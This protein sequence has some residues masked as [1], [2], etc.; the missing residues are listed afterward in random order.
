MSSYASQSRSAGKPVVLALGHRFAD[1]S[2]EQGVLAEAA[3]L[4]DA[5]GMPEA[6]VT[7]ALRTAHGVLIGSQ[8]SLRASDLA[9]LAACRVIVR[10]GSGVDN[11]DVQAA[12]RLGI[13]VGYVP[14]YC[15]EEVATHVVALILAANRNLLT[16]TRQA[17]QGDWAKPS[18][19]GIRRL[20]GQTAGVVGFGRIGRKVAG[21]LASLG[22]RVLVSDPALPRDVIAAAN[23]VPCELDALV[24]DCD[25][26]TLHLPLVAAT[27]GLI[28]AR[29]LGLMKP[30]AWLINAG[31]GG[32]VDEEALLA[33]LKGGR[34]GGAALDVLAEEPPAPGHPLLDMA[35]VILTPHM[36]WYSEEAVVEL[37]HGAASEMLR[38][39]REGTLG[40]PV[41][42]EA[43][44]VTATRTTTSK[45]ESE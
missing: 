41:T 13:Q 2:V 35:N 5:T 45:G 17:R 3:E 15:S 40:A 36:A 22:L 33:A 32:L 44:D 9:D 27:R 24:A 29:R 14:D 20:N 43:A 25:Y 21:K 34:L 10:Y 42:I 18:L 37:R 8:K 26:V 7:A 1:L 4:I 11:V 12:A 39:L 19:R 38:F 23:F 30:G 16:A 28:D 31:R 6:E